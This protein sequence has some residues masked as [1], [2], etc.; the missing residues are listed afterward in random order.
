MN[1]NLARDKYHNRDC[2]GSPEDSDC[3]YGNAEQ[4]RK[5]SEFKIC[6][7]ATETDPNHKDT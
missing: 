6:C 1:P 3:F 2:L 5:K 4:N 7:V